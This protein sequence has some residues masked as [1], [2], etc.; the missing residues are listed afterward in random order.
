MNAM[1]QG[2]SMGMNNMNQGMNVG[3]NAMNHGSYG[4]QQGNMGANM[5]MAGQA[6]TPG[7]FAIPGLEG[8]LGMVLALLIWALF[9]AGSVFLAKGIWD[10]LQAR[11]PSL[12][13]ATE[14]I[15]IK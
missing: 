14:A 4:W 1:N 15:E 6:N 8:L 13:V 11:K 3:M 7:M 2:I 5:A 10:H 12:N 9:I